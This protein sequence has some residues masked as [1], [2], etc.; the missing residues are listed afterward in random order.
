MAA[1]GS[2]AEPASGAVD[3]EAL[4][5][6]IQALTDRLGSS[7]D[8]AT[9]AVAEELMA[10]VIQ[11]YGE[12]LERILE[13]VAAGPSAEAMQGALMEDPLVATM[14]MIHDLHPVPIEDR[15]REALEKVRPYM[16]SHG[17]DVELLGI[18]EGVVHL[19]LEGSCKTCSA[20]SSTLEL[21]VRQALEETA[22]DLVGMEVEGVVEPE[23]TP[24]AGSALPLAGDDGDPRSGGFQLPVINGAAPAPPAAP[25]WFDVGEVGDVGPERIV[26]AEIAGNKLVIANVEGTLL[27]Y[28]NA[29]A[30]CGGALD[31]GVLSDGALQCPSCSRT[32][33]L[34]RAGRSTDDERLMLAPVPLLR[35][36]G[37]VKVALAT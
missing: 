25:A 6:H 33:F 23:L 2:T 11:M 5:E 27:A 30:S 34:P 8:A 18:D 19:R 7:G 22:P 37:N 36:E 1:H 9:R 16:E 10:S 31:G 17:G 14:L 29:C 20:S 26:A 13:V 4:I 21:A 15:V 24:A 35:E 28:R 32:F 12:G 3:P